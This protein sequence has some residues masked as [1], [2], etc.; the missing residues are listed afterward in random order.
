LSSVYIDPMGNL[1]KQQKILRAAR[2]T[3]LRYGYKRASMADIASASG[4]S[5]PALYLEFNSKEDVFCAVFDDWA[6]ETLAQIARDIAPLETP[7]QKVMLA[8]ELWA[9]D[10]F[11][12]ALASPDARELLECNFDFAQPSLRTGY[13]RLEE[14]IADVIAPLV[15]QRSPAIEAR[16]AAIVMTGAMRGFKQVARSG[17]ELRQLIDDLVTLLFP[18]SL[19]ASGI[20]LQ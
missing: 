14:L 17:A 19:T 16:N 9:V 7:Q 5:R 10:T 20:A 12:L 18:T 15:A 3:F 6:D 4:I 2:D 1:A 13:A 8:F 11:D